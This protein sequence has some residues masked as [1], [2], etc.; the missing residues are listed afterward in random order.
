MLAWQRTGP[1]PQALLCEPAVCSPR[2]WPCSAHTTCCH[3]G[4]ERSITL[5]GH[6]QSPWGKPVIRKPCAPRRQ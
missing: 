1:R 3:I 5:R 2:L 6:T 4:E